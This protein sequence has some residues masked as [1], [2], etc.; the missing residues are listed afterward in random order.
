[1]IQLSLS[2][3][4]NIYGKLGTGSKKLGIDINTLIINILR[5]WIDR[6]RILLLTADDISKEYENSLSIYSRGTQR[7]KARIVRSFL[8]WC[9]NRN[10]GFDRIGIDAIESF[11]KEIE[12]RYTPKYVNSYRATLRD[13]IYWFHQKY[14]V[15]K[16]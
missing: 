12:G 8:E 4:E 14:G 2:I 10:I 9:E 16:S 3:D 11:V 1:M 6:N 15:G 5:G 7:A 13:F